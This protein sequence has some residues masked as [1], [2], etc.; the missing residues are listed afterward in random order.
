LEPVSCLRVC[1]RFKSGKR[2]DFVVRTVV[3]VFAVDP[4]TVYRLRKPDSKKKT[5][6][7]PIMSG[8][9]SPFGTSATATPAEGI[10]PIVFLSNGSSS[11][12]MTTA[13]LRRENMLWAIRTG[14]QCSA[15]AWIDGWSNRPDIKDARK[16]ERAKEPW[17]ER[18]WR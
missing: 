3:Q 17:T 16:P 15:S 9:F 14:W 1:L 5:W 6:E 18:A 2:L 8:H 12:K 7:L 11:L 10:L 13:S 4:N